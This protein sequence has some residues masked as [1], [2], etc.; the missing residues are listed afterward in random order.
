MAIARD[1]SSPTPVYGDT[2]ASASLVT[3]SFTPPAGSIVVAYVVSADAQVTH[4]GVTGLTFTKRVDV[5]TSGSTTRNSL[6]TAT[7]AGSA[8]T[9]TAAFTGSQARGLFVDVWTGTQLAATPATDSVVGGSGAP[10]DTITTVAANSVVAW[11]CGDWAQITGT[12]TYRSSATETAYKTLTG[13]YTAETAWQSAVTAGS[14]TYGL[15]APTGQTYTMVAIELQ[16]SG[17]GAPAI[18]PF[19]TMQTRRAF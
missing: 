11:S 8:V 3:A 7:G 14:Q 2:N 19:L 6:W 10:T 4:T 5:G 17:G 1:A 12:R 18:P 9:V 15:T 13:N 16:D